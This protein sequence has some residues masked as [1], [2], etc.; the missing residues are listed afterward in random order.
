MKTREVICVVLV[1]IFLVFGF[2]SGGSATN[3]FRTEKIGLGFKIT[4]L[5]LMLDEAAFHCKFDSLEK[6]DKIFKGMNSDVSRMLQRQGST[7]L[8]I[9]F[10]L[11]IVAFFVLYSGFESKK[12]K[13]I[14]NTFNILFSLI[15]FILPK[16][17]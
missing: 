16:I 14:M 6:V 13:W 12:T 8:D 7:A 1:N 17:Q 10:F 5:Q 4:E 3:A 9:L 11:S 15:Y 2:L